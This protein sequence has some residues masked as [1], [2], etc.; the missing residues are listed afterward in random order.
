MAGKHPIRAAYTLPMRELSGLATRATEGG[1]VE[2]LTIGDAADTIGIVRLP[3]HEGGPVAFEHADLRGLRRAEGAPQWEAIM[4]DQIGQVAVLQ[5]RPGGVAFLSP[6]LDRLL[7][8]LRFDITE[9]DVPG[10]ERDEN[11]RGEGLLLLANGHFLLVK[12]KRPPLLI[13]VGPA[14]EPA[15]GVDVDLLKDSTLT[16]PDDGTTFSPL[17]VWR[18]DE[19]ILADVSDI[20]VS[21][22]GRL[23]VLSDEERAIAEVE[24]PLLPG[25]A[26]VLSRTWKLPKRITK[27]EGLVV[28]DGEIPVVVSDAGKNEEN[29]FVLEPLA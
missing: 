23:Y 3:E 22:S 18:F 25:A 10:W 21:S 28:L 26:L 15:G 8:T 14:G 2:L 6:R 16:V 27:P 17:A 19:S 13:E 4:T 29:L 7:G 20:A 24:L 9:R 11:S 1:G 5:E 12:E